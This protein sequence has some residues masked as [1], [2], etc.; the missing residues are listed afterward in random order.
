MDTKLVRLNKFLADAGIAS[1]RKADYFISIGLVSINGKVVSE[2][3]TKVDPSVD[4]VTY[5]GKKVNVP[6]EK[7]YVLLNKPKGCITSVEDPEGRNTVMDYVKGIHVRIF[8]VGRLDY[9]SEGLLLLTNDGDFANRIMHPRFEIKKKYL[10][11]LSRMP[12]IQEIKRLEKGMYIDGV[13]LSPCQIIILSNEP[14]EVYLEIILQEGKNREI[15]RMFEFFNYNVISLK[16]IQ[17]GNLRLG[18]VPSGK[19][20]LLSKKEVDDFLRDLEK[21]E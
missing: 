6:D 9:N 16:R 10:V 7:V 19:F 5:D 17:L 13:K 20:R 3:G 14:D 2:V 1:R 12:D 21:H 18:T 4:D 11:Q 15:R 8:P